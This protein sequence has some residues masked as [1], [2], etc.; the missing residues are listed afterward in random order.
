MADSPLAAIL[1]DDLPF[2]ILDDQVAKQY[3]PGVLRRAG[4]GWGFLTVSAQWPTAPDHDLHDEDRWWTGLAEPPPT[5][6]AVRDL[7]L[8]PD[9]R[10]HDALALLAHDPAIAPLLTDRDGYTAWWLREHA[11]TNGREVRSYRR[12]DAEAFAGIVDPLD[13]PDAAAMGGIVVDD[14]V[15]DTATAALIL[16][17]LGDA[18]RRVVP[19]AVVRGY[20][21]VVAAIA[22]GD[23]DAGIGGRAA[24]VVGEKLRATSSAPT[25][26]PAARSAPRSASQES[27][28]SARDTSIWS[29]PCSRSRKSGEGAHEASV[30]LPMPGAPW[31][32]MRG[33]PATEPRETLK[34][35]GAGCAGGPFGRC[36]CGACGAFTGVLR[37][38]MV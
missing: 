18:D 37:C 36:C 5:M 33:A 16:T 13:H 14:V 26:P 7:D 11:R 34:R 9:D 3:G 23:V 38:S 10:W 28:P 30:D 4:V 22:R 27:I 21:E 19:G 24:S 12:P 29:V 35:K 17:N 15:A 32:T 20:G 25:R 2:A 31:S 1:G 6:M 8:V